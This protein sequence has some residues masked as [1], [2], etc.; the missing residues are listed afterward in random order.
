MQRK[1]NTILKIC[2]W[3]VTIILGFVNPLISIALIVLHYL[4][5]IISD[6]I[7]HCDEKQSDF[8]IKSYSEKVLEDMK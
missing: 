2:F 8:G 3:G 6:L 1:M 7:Q 5:K 4:L